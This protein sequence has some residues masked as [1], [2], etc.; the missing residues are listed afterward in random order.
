MVTPQGFNALL[1]IVEEPPENVRLQV[2]T[3]VDTNKDQAELER[4]RQRW[5]YM[6]HEYKGKLIRGPH[7]HVYEKRFVEMG[8]HPRIALWQHIELPN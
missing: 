5:P 7:F 4:N 6:Y 8:M 1:K 3:Y 2:Y